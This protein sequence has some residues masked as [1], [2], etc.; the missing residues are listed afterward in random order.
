MLSKAMPVALLLGAI[1]ARA[2]AL[3]WSRVLVANDNATA[4]CLDD[5][6]SDLC[7]VPAGCTD[8]PEMDLCDG[9]CPDDVDTDLCDWMTPAPAPAPPAPATNTRFVV[10]SQP[11]TVEDPEGFANEPDVEVALAHTYSALTGALVS[12]ILI[13]VEVASHRRLQTQGAARRLAGEVIVHF[14]IAVD[15]TEAGSLGS[16]VNALAQLTADRLKAQVESDLRERAPGVPATVA[17][18][19]VATASVVAEALLTTTFNPLETEESEGTDKK[20]EADVATIA[21]V[22]SVAA[23][24]IG[25][26]ALGMGVA[27]FLQRRRRTPKSSN[28]EADEEKDLPAISEAVVEEKDIRAAANSQPS[29]PPAQFVVPIDSR[30]VPVADDHHNHPAEQV[31]AV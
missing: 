25:I 10:G 8:E 19:S 5:P 4:G 23:V 3:E 9:V 15:I 16:V 13:D 26:K 20:P 12:R 11:L 21:I 18:S 2:A 22:L 6:D 14:Q 31:E 28:E 1:A 29:A 7:D 30:S 24:A 27:L 17:V